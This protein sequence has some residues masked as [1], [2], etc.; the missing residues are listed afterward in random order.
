MID[1]FTFFVFRLILEIIV[2][3]DLGLLL[4]ILADWEDDLNH[5]NYQHGK[6]E[7]GLHFGK[8]FVQ[9]EE[10]VDRDSRY[11]DKDDRVRDRDRDYDDGGLGTVN[12]NGD[13]R[14]QNQ[15]DNFVRT[16]QRRNTNSRRHEEFDDTSVAKR[17]ALHDRNWES[18]SKTK[19]ATSWKRTA[20]GSGGLY[21][22]GG[23][24]E[25]RIYEEQL[26]AALKQEL[27][28]SKAKHGSGIDVK[29]EQ[30]D[31]SGGTYRHNESNDEGSVL[32]AN[33]N[34]S[35]QTRP[36]RVEDSFLED[37]DD[38]YV[39]TVSEYEES[40]L[41]E[42]DDHV[43]EVEGLSDDSFGARGT[44]GS[45]EVKATAK[46]LNGVNTQDRFN[47]KNQNEVSQRKTRRRRRAGRKG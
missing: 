41:T 39:D 4:V 36:D 35:N 33:A 28:S 26:E 11:W 7:R 27:D 18:E 29:Y 38:E 8:A 47:S 45:A 17:Y 12:A 46:A 43:E 40:A 25:L 20:S 24:K 42:D 13:S 23:R 30:R 10:L 37:G 19:Q 9:K 22:E 2:M 3:P 6:K 21:N 15:R 32:N 31:R 1:I 44:D 34:Q 16:E 14:Q 5:E